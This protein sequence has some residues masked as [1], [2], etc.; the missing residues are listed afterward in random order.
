MGYQINYGPV[1]TKNSI[2]K[3][4]KTV[5]VL[6]LA[7]CIIAL[8]IGLQVSGAGNLLWKWMLPGDPEVTGAALDTMVQGLKEGSS[9]GDAITAF[10]REIID[11][12]H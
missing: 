12:A 7:I 11:N 4:D 6:L 5:R 2:R 10:C 8:V 3:K 1:K 9:V